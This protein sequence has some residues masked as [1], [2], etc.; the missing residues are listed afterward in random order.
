MSDQADVSRGRVLRLSTAAVTAAPTDGT[1]DPAMVMSSRTPTG[2]ETTGLWIGLKAP[3]A[4]SATAGAGGFTVTVYVR[5]PTTGA[6][7]SCSS[8]SMAYGQAFV[9]FDFNA[10]ELYFQITNV[11][12]AGNVDVHVWEQ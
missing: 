8:T 1:T 6:W 7:F 9:T 2:L 4:G 3:T 11:A 10:S 12:V 5:N